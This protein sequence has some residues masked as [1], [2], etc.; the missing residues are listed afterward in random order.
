M[1]LILIY[2]IF[3]TTVGESGLLGLEIPRRL[4]PSICLA[5]V[6][7]SPFPSSSDF[8]RRLFCFQFNFILKINLI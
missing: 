3:G 6:L 4:S 2:D 5:E 1:L 7:F 8:L